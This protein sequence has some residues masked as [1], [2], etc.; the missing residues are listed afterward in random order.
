MFIGRYV[1]SRFDLAERPFIEGTYDDLITVLAR[2]YREKSRVHY[3]GLENLPKDHALVLCGNHHKLDDPIIMWRAAQQAGGGRVHLKI[4]MRDDYFTTKLLNNPFIDSVEFFSCLGAYPITRDK[5][6]LK[7]LRPFMECLEPN[8]GFIM[9]P[10]RTRTRSGMF[11]EYRDDFVEP[12]G[13]SFFLHQSQRRN[14]AL[15]ICALPVVRTFNPASKRTMM[16][17]GEPLYLEHD[18][19]R[20]AQRNFDAHLIEVMSG[21]VELNVPHVL[22]SILYLRTLHG[23]IEPVSIDALVKSVRSVFETVKHPYVDA[24][25][26]M[27]VNAAVVRTA[28]FFRKSAMVH[29]RGNKVVPIREAILST[30]DLDP[31]Y[32]KINPVKY[33]TNQI[34]HLGEVT[35]QVEKAVLG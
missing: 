2:F 27:D 29:T 22:A 18:A 32:K 23:M 35:A 16:T 31:R 7:Q 3:Q 8:N 28:K 6:S 24:H 9:F 15:P 5:V 10:G 19:D 33:L 21:L 34:L 20:E 25:D 11:I 26:L 14:K 30:P 12:G 1:L 17:M 4:M 13:V